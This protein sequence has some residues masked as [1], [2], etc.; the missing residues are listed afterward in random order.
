[1]AKFDVSRVINENYQFCI[2]LLLTV[3]QLVMT[4]GA[5]AWGPLA[6]FL[7]ADFGITRAQTGAIVSALYAASVLIA[8]PS[9]L[10]VD[11]FGAKRMLIVALATM[12]F[13]FT[14]LSLV[15]SFL[16]FVVFAGVSGIGYGAINQI[17]SKG[18]VQW[19]P[20]K[21]RA[22]AMGIKQSGV[23]LGGALGAVMLP[24][25]VILASRRWATFAV[26]ITMVIT[27]FL[28][29]LLYREHPAAA[30]M[31]DGPSSP[32]V[33]KR[34]TS[35]SKDFKLL[36]KKPELI[37]LCFVSM[38]LAASQSSIASFMVLYMQEELHTS[39]ASAGLGLSVFMIAGTVGRVMW[40]MISDRIFKG[41][42]QYPM[43]LLCLIAS[44][45]ALGMVVSAR[46]SM[47]WLPYF[48]NAVMGFTFM[49]WNALFITFTAEIAGPALVGLVTGLT[50]TVSWTGII[51]GPPLFGLIADK[52]GYSWSW[53]MLTIFGV[54]CAISLYYS[55]TVTK[56]RAQGAEITT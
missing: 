4:L 40:G 38:L 34:A 41:D 19:F 16:M 30:V 2:L 12:G 17:S 25:I 13:A 5:Y 21:N 47:A 15:D 3:S 32:P 45:S 33:E 11:K 24:A 23:T 51:A 27:A 14:A 35:R 22:T 46:V 55:S 44:G 53:V 54:L 43:L 26:A 49:G 9:G 29:A 48:I 28:V 50:I 36:L 1:M 42:R 56:K 7:R 10:A 8:M 37:V 20:K 18:I 39:A 31:T 6:P 52:V